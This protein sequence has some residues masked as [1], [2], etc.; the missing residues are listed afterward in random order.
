MSAPLATAVLALL[1][2]LS[3]DAPWV[4]E[5]TAF[6]GRA[7]LEIVAAPTDE[8]RVGAVVEAVFDRFDE[9]EGLVNLWSADSVL[10][11]WN[12]GEPAAERPWPEPLTP[13]LRSAL[14]FARESDGAF[15]PTVGAVLADLGFYGSSPAATVDQD[16]GRR[17][18]ERVGH[19]R[20]ALLERDGGAVVRTTLVRPR[21]DLS[22]LAKGRAA[23]DASALLGRAGIAS[24]RIAVG[25]S[26]IHALGAGPPSAEGRGWPVALP[27]GEGDRTFWLRDEALATSGRLSLV[28]ELEDGP[29]S[30]VI[31]PRSCRPVDHRTAM[32]AVLGPDPVQADMA[33]T[34]LLV[35]G[36]DEGRAWIDARPGWR[37]RWTAIFWSVPPGD[38]P[39]RPPT[40]EIVV[41]GR[42]R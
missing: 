15:D 27:W 42:A 17:W 3:D 1:P 28:I 37:E 8:E 20:V 39:A 26:S 16:S 13:L 25:S 34:A 33:S 32:V 31:D 38:D 23:A 5:R 22:A 6:G 12:A 14:D 29:V 40:P 19:A 10:S 35:M 24:A 9:L 30:H 21:F 7:T 18:R 41:Y 4:F 11:R 2:A 36:V